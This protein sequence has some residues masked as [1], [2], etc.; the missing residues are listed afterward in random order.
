[1]YTALVSFL[2]VLLSVAVYSM[3]T[4]LIVNER[5]VRLEEISKLLIDH[6]NVDTNGG[7]DLDQ[8]T[9]PIGEACVYQLW[10][11]DGQLEAVSESASGITGV[12]DRNAITQD[13]TMYSE[14]SV[15]NSSYRI[16]SV[17][18]VVDGE[19]YGWLQVG[20]PLDVVQNTQRQMMVIFSVFA[21]LAILVVGFVGWFGAGQALEPLTTMLNV[22]REIS[23]SDDLSKRIP[24]D[25]RHNDEMN[26]LALTFN[27]TLVRLERLFKAQRRFL[28]DVSHELRTPLTVIKGNVGLM[29][30]T[31][32]I[33]EES[34]DSISSEADRLTRLVGDLLL[35]SQAE[36]G[37]L[38]LMEKPV[39]LD[40]L[41]FEVFEEMKILSEGK[42]DIQIDY[43]EP[44]V[45]T[46]DRDRLKQVFLNLGSNAV[47][48]SP[49]GTKI[50]L[51]LQRK[52]EWVEVVVRDEG[53]GIP[54]EELGRLFERFYRGDKSRTRSKSDVGYGLGLPIAYWIVRS[55][56]GRIDVDTEVNQGTTF[57]VRLP[58]S[59]IEVPTRPLRSRQR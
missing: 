20:T 4:V 56:K 25:T 22:T 41:L 54:K 50:T 38:P 10:S 32:S 52:R 2:V 8:A 14:V 53:Y 19:D 12:L 43:I 37:N 49:E 44:T 42:H 16:L 47:K 36:S 45:I 23:S 31:K 28:A 15:E 5:D 34:L 21:I 33:D 35:I 24:V 51:S 29:R 30:M 46:G 6:L 13:I 57:T 26:E 27:Q 18:I 40:Q 11:K 55:H 39:E 17:P 9:L 58:S 48:Y 59:N 3:V 7:I 1:M